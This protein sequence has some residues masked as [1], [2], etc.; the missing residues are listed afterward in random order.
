MIGELNALK[1]VLGAMP[2]MAGRV[3]IG[4]GT[5]ALPPFIVL[6]SGPGARDLDVGID[7]CGSIGDT[8][9]VTFTAGTPSDA[10][11]MAADGIELLT[12]GRNPTSRTIP[13]RLFWLGTPECRPVQIDR[14]V[15][16]PDS[17]AHPAYV[18][19]LFQMSSH[20]LESP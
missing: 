7:A 16:L 15:T 2:G 20:P 5:G 18:V 11:R 1:T 8:L 12:P 4:D 3:L 10:L 17:G 19:A 9:G 14:E 13:G 6:W